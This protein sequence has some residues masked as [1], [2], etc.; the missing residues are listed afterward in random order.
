MATN[1]KTTYVEIPTEELEKIQ[2]MIPSA[3]EVKKSKIDYTR[4]P[5]DRHT[6]NLAHNL[7]SEVAIDVLGA[8]KIVG[9]NF[10][11][12]FEGVEQL[13]RNTSAV[14][15]FDLFTTISNQMSEPLARIHLD[16]YMNLRGVKDKKTARKQVQED[17][18]LLEQVHMKYKGTKKNKGD[19]LNFYLF[20]GS[21]GI[22]NSVIYFRFN[23]DYFRTIPRKQFAYL[24]EEYYKFND[25]KNPH[26]TYFLRRICV[27]KRINIG[28]PNENIIGV[29]T[30]IESSPNFPEYKGDFTQ[31]ILSKFERDMDVITCFSWYYCG[32]NEKQIE[33]PQSYDEFIKTNVK[34]EW[35][36]YIDTK[37]LVDNKKKGKK[38]AIERKIENKQ[39]R[40]LKE[41]LMDLERKLPN[42]E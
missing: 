5:E 14:R 38:K 7:T 25:Y 12:T 3:K 34:L 9:E 15:L 35:N 40:E 18:K 17:L 24:P 16:D 29:K 2:K 31:K 19:W 30:L 1:K 4:L 39:I 36:D 22:K 23:E 33:P 26:T 21:S 8:R 37:E 20:G 41:K 28:E 32:K 13:K 10:E 11:I 6:N 42:K 27:H